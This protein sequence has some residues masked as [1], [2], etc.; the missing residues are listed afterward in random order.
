MVRPSVWVRNTCVFE[1]VC[2]CEQLQ[3]SNG[4]TV[5]ECESKCTFLT[6]SSFRLWRV[7]LRL[8][9]L[10]LEDCFDQLCLHPAHMD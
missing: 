2:T 9:I 1:E 5:W 6:P 3:E 4:W 8:F 7:V 10:N